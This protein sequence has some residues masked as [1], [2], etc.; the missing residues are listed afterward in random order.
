MEKSDLSLRVERKHLSRGPKRGLTGPILLV[1]N[2]VAG[3]WLPKKGGSRPRYPLTHVPSGSPKAVSREPPECHE[4]TSASASIIFSGT[5]T[6]ARDVGG[7]DSPFEEMP[8]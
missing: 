3:H 8:L 2:P 5:A 6:G 7:E 4:A 1:I